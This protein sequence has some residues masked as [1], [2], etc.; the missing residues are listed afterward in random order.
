ML[1]LRIFR[2]NFASE[3]TNPSEYAEKVFMK[4]SIIIIE[5]NREIASFE[6]VS[7]EGIKVIKTEANNGENIKI[8]KIYE[9]SML[10]VSTIRASMKQ[11]WQS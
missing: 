10:I 5:K 2:E 7:A 4:A 9:S 1:K 11:A 3:G 6:A 8:W